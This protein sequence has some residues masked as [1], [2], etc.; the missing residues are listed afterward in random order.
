[1][2]VRTSALILRSN[3]GENMAFAYSNGAVQLFHNNSKKFE[4]TTTGIDVTG[5][6]DTDTLNVSSTSTFAGAI[7]ANGDL[8]VDG[9]TELDD[10]N[11][12]GVST[13]SSNVA[14]TA[15]VGIGTT[16]N[17]YYLEV[18]PVGASGT[19]LLVN[20]DLYVAGI[21]TSQNTIEHKI[22]DDISSSFNGST[23]EFT[24]ASGGDNF[25]N[26]EILTPARLMISVGGIVQQP[27][28]NNQ[29]GYNITGGTNR[30]TDPL[31]I[32]FAEAPKLGEA[33][34]GVAYG[35]QIE[36]QD[37]YITYNDSLVNAIVFGV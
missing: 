18:G 19:S 28:L 27:D 36:K 32:N 23:T 8:D 12:S 15:N 24:L 21:I 7:D 11:V 4:T 35:L 26:S 13:F 31:K 9:H 20:G 30:T 22:L 3:V 6:T 2:Q 29:K 37:A 10:L 17:D 34:F 25:I 5:L 33:F 14:V 16:T 1:L